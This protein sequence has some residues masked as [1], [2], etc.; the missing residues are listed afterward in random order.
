MYAAPGRVEVR[1]KI[2]TGQGLWPAFWM[3]GQGH[4]ATPWPD[5]GELDIM[6]NK[7]SQPRTTSSAIH[8]PGY[9]GSASLNHALTVDQAY[10][11]AFHT[12][13]VEWD[14]GSVRFFVDSVPHLILT[15]ESVERAGPSVL[16]RSYYIVLNLAVGGFFDGDPASDA[17]LPATMLVD[18]VRVYRAASTR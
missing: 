11:D 9:A 13:A 10:A 12:F 7:G 6:E 15:R 8:G 17:I 3:L 5:C 2:P 16:N 4:P 14:A 18:Y 1:I